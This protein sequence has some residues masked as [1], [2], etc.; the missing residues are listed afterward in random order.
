MG[1][2]N[3]A[4]TASSQFQKTASNKPEKL[5]AV[6]E[7]ADK[8]DVKEN[9]D[10]FIDFS[11]L[12]LPFRTDPGWDIPHSAKNFDVEKAEF[13]KF[14]LITS[15]DASS[16]GCTAV[17]LLTVNSLRFQL[18]RLTRVIDLVRSRKQYL[19]MDYANVMYDWIQTLQVR[20]LQPLLACIE[21][22]VLPE[23]GH[24]VFINEESPLHVDARKATFAEVG[25]A[26]DAVIGTSNALTPRLPSGERVFVLIYKVFQFEQKLLALLDELV[27]VGIPQRQ[28]TKAAQKKVAQL[29]KYVFQILSYEAGIKP[30]P[31]GGVKFDNRASQSMAGVLTAWM[32]EQQVIAMRKRIGIKFYNRRRGKAFRAAASDYGDTKESNFIRKFESALESELKAAKKTAQAHHDITKM[33][34]KMALM[35]KREKARSRKERREN[36][37]DEED[38][39]DADSVSD[40]H[41]LTEGED[42][43]GDEKNTENRFV[44]K[45]EL[46]LIYQNVYH[47]DDEGSD[48]ASD[49]TTP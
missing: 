35:R 5:P 31:G 6:E 41:S 38:S 48:V 2:K 13:G 42:K 25:R 19:T 21:N 33:L 36:G 44:D 15:L 9:S 22:D 8:E 20:R 18:L 14:E 10:L 34:N 17:V 30:A 11:P 26:L 29:E 47:D 16:N 3:F 37:S 46:I 23:L 49:V 39:S 24:V 32:S 45:K 12:N 40:G 27:A 7:T 43:D 28:L 4:R 1:M